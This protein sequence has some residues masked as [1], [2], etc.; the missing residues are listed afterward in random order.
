[1]RP[2]CGGVAAVAAA[3]ALLLAVGR[4]AAAWAHGLVG[5]ADLP[6]PGWLFGWAAAV[7]LVVSFVALATLWPTPRLQQPRERRLMALPAWVAGAC[8]ALGVGLFGLVV[9]AGFAGTKEAALNL[10][11]NVIYVH[12]WVGMVVA[13]VLLGDVFAAFNPWRAVGR[14]SGWLVHRVAGTRPKTRSI[15]LLPLERLGNR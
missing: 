6:V 13:S 9:Y 11:P 14:A 12:F 7:V 8:G 1:M 15:V 10:A 3:F 5:R 2:R 4:P